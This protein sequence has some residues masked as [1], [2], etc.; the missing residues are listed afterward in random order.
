[1]SYSEVQGWFC[2]KSS[3]LVIRRHVAC[4]VRLAESRDL[5]VR[6]SHPQGN[7]STLG[8]TGTG[9]VEISAFHIWL[10]LILITFRT[11][12][13]N[14]NG[15]LTHKHSDNGKSLTT[16][17]I[18]VERREKWKLQSRGTMSPTRNPLKLGLCKKSMPISSKAQRPQHAGL[19]PLPHP[20][21]LAKRQPG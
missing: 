2:I 17:Q 4:W 16:S 10:F 18:K 13:Q 9:Q 1:M 8:S 21:C 3:W 12:T 15:A 20:T 11:G 6:A 7:N 14:Q 5:E 19:I